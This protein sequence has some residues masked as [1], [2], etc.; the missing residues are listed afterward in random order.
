MYRISSWLNATEENDNP[1]AGVLV[2]VVDPFLPKAGYGQCL[3]HTI[4]RAYDLEHQ[5]DADVLRQVKLLDWLT[6]DGRVELEVCFDELVPVTETAYWQLL[7]WM[8]VNML[9]LYGVYRRSLKA[10]RNEFWL[11][12]AIK[13]YRLTEILRVLDAWRANNED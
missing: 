5:I 12:E 6:R 1:F 3:V 8:K 4:Y 7:H 13:N 10:G 2:K 9:Q 11:E